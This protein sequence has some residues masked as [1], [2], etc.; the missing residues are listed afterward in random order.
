MRKNQFGT[1]GN[2][3]TGVN[4]VM[5]KA[6]EALRTLWEFLMVWRCEGGETRLTGSCTLFSEDGQLKVCFND[7]DTGCIS[8]RTLE[9]L[10][11]CLAVLDELLGGQKLDWRRA[12]DKSARRS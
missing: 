11:G 2:K 10:S 9:G 12:K 4:P 3:N 1:E 7:R 6:D 8:F 5:R